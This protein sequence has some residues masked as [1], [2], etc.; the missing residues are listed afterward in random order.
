MNA[1][2]TEE[3][4][5]R[6]RNLQSKLQHLGVGNTDADKSFDEELGLWNWRCQMIS[7]SRQSGT[8]SISFSNGLEQCE[9]AL[10][11]IWESQSLSFK[12]LL[13]SRNLQSP[14]PDGRHFNSDNSVLRL[15]C[16]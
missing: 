3:V 4:R 10:G 15:L 13:S 9:T 11:L 8:T 12:N 7:V 1:M 6:M 5:D 14:I 16:L 2:T